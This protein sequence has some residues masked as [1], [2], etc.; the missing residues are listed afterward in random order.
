MKTDVIIVGGGHAGIEAALAARRLGASVILVTLDPAAIGRMSCNPS[1]GGL[2]KGQL[3]R[4]VDAL[5][6]LMGVA[7]DHTA[8]QF[9]M[10]NTS[11]G[12]AVQ[13]PRAQVDKEAY[14]SFV[15]ST[16]LGTEGL[17]VVAGQVASVVER[18]G[19][20]AGV[21]LSDGSFLPARTAVLTT[22]TFLRGLMHVGDRR[23]AGGRLGEAPAASLSACLSALGLE[24]VRLKT[25]TPPRISARS[26]DLSALEQHLGSPDDGRF[27]YRVEPPRGRIA[28]PTWRTATCEA[29]HDLVRTHLQS[30][31]YGRGALKS[32]GPRYCPSLEDK[33]VRFADK[34]AHRVFIEQETLKGDALYLNGLSNCLPAEVQ[35]LLLRSLPG[36]AGAR[37]LRPG[38]AV[39][40]DAVPACQ[41]RPGLACRALPGLFLAGQI[42]GT[43]GYEEAAA[44]GLMAGLNAARDVA[45]LPP[46]A[47]G[48]HEAYVGVLIDDLTTLSPL[49][50]YRMFTS[51]AEFR[52]L[53]RQDNADRRLSDKAFAWGLISEAAHAAHVEREAALSSA[54]A[55]LGD[56]DAPLRRRL[57]SGDSWSELA[58]SSARLAKLQLP[59]EWARQVELDERYDGYV[60]RQQRA[61]AKLQRLAS[62]PLPDDLD[63]SRLEALRP[64]A[65]EVLAEARPA[66]LGQASRLA[67]V[68]PA[69][70]SLLALSR[71]DAGRA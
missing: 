30:S 37:M 38:Y 57:R 50:P 52:L 69:D 29:T 42:N 31:P 58:G 15:R 40:Y 33:V 60:R 54:R 9:R 20:L 3:A 26:V 46:V 45:G 5:G 6:G 11:K 24:L 22:G 10:L 48:R 43:S 51:R 8:M 62:V 16:L 44:Q 14:A 61:V 53:L 35:E 12:P 2:A 39:E 19:R 65:R 27:S 64:E 28:V 59:A 17:T 63:Y 36:L 67:G 66:N 13:S 68:T 41:L 21:E 55:A 18:R 56:G 49:E 4:E 1:I 7:A 71:S 32:A 34:S 25:G 70:L 47:L 23:S